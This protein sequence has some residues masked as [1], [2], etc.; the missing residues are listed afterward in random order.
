MKKAIKS[1]FPLH[2][3]LTSLKVSLFLTDDFSGCPVGHNTKPHAITV[4][5]LDKELYYSIRSY[6]FSYKQ[7]R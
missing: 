4:F 1:K 6:N 2:V 5:N 3:F 7:S